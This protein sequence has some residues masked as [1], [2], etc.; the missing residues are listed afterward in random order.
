[1]K[2]TGK[3]SARDA[4]VNLYFAKAVAQNSGL[5]KPLED[6][7]S[8]VFGGLTIDGSTLPKDSVARITSI[9]SMF[10]MAASNRAATERHPLLW[11]R[12]AIHHSDRAAICPDAL[13]DFSDWRDNY[14]APG[15]W[16]V[17]HKKK[18]DGKLCQI[19][20]HRNAFGM[21]VGYTLEEFLFC[22]E[23]DCGCKADQH[24]LEWKAKRYKRVAQQDA[25][26]SQ[27]GV[28]DLENWRNVCGSNVLDQVARCVKHAAKTN[29]EFLSN[30]K[31]KGRYSCEV[32]RNELAQWLIDN[33]ASLARYSKTSIIHAISAVA[34]CPKGNKKRKMRIKKRR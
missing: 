18:E 30:K 32:S 11:L 19:N 17:S 16:F 1:M 6:A 23:L 15:S 20:R 13:R 24:E 10:R 33:Y 25:A 27:T 29:H 31:T 22:K 21:T 4:I 9:V 34:S 5:Q 7:I 8:R 26:A 12:I 14:P 3:W 2:F 28:R